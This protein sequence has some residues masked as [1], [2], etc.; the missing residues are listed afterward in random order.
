MGTGNDS[1]CNQ[2]HVILR[3]VDFDFDPDYITKKLELKPLSIGRQGEEYFVGP[4]QIC[5]V[6]EFNHWDYEIKTKNNDFIGDTV[7]LFFN[8]IIS[9]R[10]DKIK[11]ISLK[12]KITRLTIVQY[13]Y[14]GHNPGYGFEREQVKILTDINAEIDMDIYCLA[15]D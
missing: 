14:S 9:P 8:K 11:E 5:K 12:S 2:N 4:Q 15:D 10:L 1:Q 7:D 3:F 6:W 13:Y